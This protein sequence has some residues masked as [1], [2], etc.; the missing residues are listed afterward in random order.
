MP[1]HYLK[2][3]TT[4]GNDEKDTY[5]L[6]SVKSNVAPMFESKLLQ[7]NAKHRTKASVAKHKI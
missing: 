6:R 2:H 4:N 5:R 7:S 1:T 3:E